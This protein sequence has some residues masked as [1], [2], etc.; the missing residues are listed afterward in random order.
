MKIASLNG[1]TSCTTLGIIHEMYALETSILLAVRGLL[2]YLT[3]SIEQA[4]VTTI[5]ESEEIATDWIHKTGNG[6][7]QTFH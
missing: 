1:T 3:L 6:I 7:K 4:L 2:K 5:R